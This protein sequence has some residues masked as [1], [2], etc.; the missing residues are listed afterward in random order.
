MCFEGTAAPTE[1]Q[2]FGKQKKKEQSSRTKSWMQRASWHQHFPIM[3]CQISSHWLL[4]ILSR[5]KL[6]Y[7]RLCCVFAPLDP[8]AF[9]LQKQFCT[10]FLKHNKI[11]C[12]LLWMKYLP[13]IVFL[14]MYL[15]GQGLWELAWN[16]DN[17]YL[18][19]SLV[20]IAEQIDFMNQSTVWI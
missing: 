3:K 9:S 18:K 7:C 5:K 15:S 16:D 19:I 1:Q 8:D 17:Y 2:Q 4:L 12:C 11:R 14:Y 6:H 20:T 10:C 13:I